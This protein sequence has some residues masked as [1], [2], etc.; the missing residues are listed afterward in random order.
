[1]EQSRT[2]TGVRAFGDCFEGDL[3]QLRAYT[4]YDSRLA[5]VPCGG[6][7]WGGLTQNP[8]VERISRVGGAGSVLLLGEKIGII[9]GGNNEDSDFHR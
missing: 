5:G 7:G 2:G 4:Y 3:G 8:R 6:R 1:M 9:V